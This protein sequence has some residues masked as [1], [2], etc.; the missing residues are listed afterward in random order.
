V[1]NAG[2]CKANPQVREEKIAGMNVKVLSEYRSSVKTQFITLSMPE[3]SYSKE[4][5]IRIW[6]YCCEKYT[7]RKDRL[8]LRIYVNGSYEFNRQFNGWPV[9]SHT[10]EAISPNGTRVKLRGYE[11]SFLRMGKGALAHDGDN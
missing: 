2:E 1:L 6:R 4:S 11:A 7:D 3:E 10:R 9:D 5:L 8:D